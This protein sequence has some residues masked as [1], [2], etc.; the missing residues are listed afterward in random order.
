MAAKQVILEAEHLARCLFHPAGFLK[1]E[2]ALI[3]RRV[4]IAQ[5]CG[6]P[7]GMTGWQPGQR[8]HQAGSQSF[9]QSCAHGRLQTP[10]AIAPHFIRV[11]QQGQQIGEGEPFL[12]WRPEEI[13]R[14][15]RCQRR[16][17]SPVA[18]VDIVPAP[19]KL[20]DPATGGK[21]RFAGTPPSRSS[22]CG[23]ASWI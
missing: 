6:K 18:I 23:A 3:Q 20:Q 11:C 2:Q 10:F 14:V 22:I 17:R 21:Q 5:G 7:A 4:E 12:R 16:A 9:D 19:S 1:M 13:G 15:Q 8:H